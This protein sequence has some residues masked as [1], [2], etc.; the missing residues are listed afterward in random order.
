MPEKRKAGEMAWRFA[1]VVLV[2][3]L[4]ACVSVPEG[5]YY[6]LDMRGSGDVETGLDVEV[7]RFHA[8]DA[9]SRPEILIQ[10]TPTRIEYYAVDQW[11]SDLAEMV[12]EK[13]QRE[14]GPASALPAYRIEGDILAFEQ[15]D[16][17]GGAEA[18]VRLR[19]RGYDASE[20]RSADAV[21]RKTYDEVVPAADATAEA[22]VAALSRALEAVAVQI[23]T[24]LSTL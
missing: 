24:D 16:L 2:T 11:A 23:A 22:V 14:F 21:L 15:M 10:A 12:Q 13:L 9:L 8:S 19:V 6:T 17:E 20:R 18:H 5:R 3:G 4:T 7:G 1:V